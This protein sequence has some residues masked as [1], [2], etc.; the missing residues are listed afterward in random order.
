M[1]GLCEGHTDCWCSVT[2]NSAVHHLRSTIVLR[3]S[4][5]V[6][7]VWLILPAHGRTDLECNTVS[8]AGIDARMFRDDGIF[9]KFDY[10]KNEQ[11]SPFPLLVRVCENAWWLQ[12]VIPYRHTDCNGAT[13][14]STQSYNAILPEWCSLRLLQV[15]NVTGTL[16]SVTCVSSGF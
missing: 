1:K 12:I 7:F 4:V 3:C 10:S 15:W 2:A 14:P 5:Y 6:P 9:F 11:K 16:C 8:A 13:S